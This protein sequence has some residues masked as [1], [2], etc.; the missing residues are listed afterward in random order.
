MGHGSDVQSLETTAIFDKATDELIL[1][2][3][4][5]SSAKYWPG[6]LGIFANYA[7]VFAR[8]IVENG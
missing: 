2:S 7:M 8:L 4:T 1:N 5:V 3:P 6:D